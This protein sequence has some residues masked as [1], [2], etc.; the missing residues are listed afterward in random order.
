MERDDEYQEYK[1]SLDTTKGRGYIENMSDNTDNSQFKEKT[2]NAEKIN[3]EK[4]ENNA[5]IKFIP[6]EICQTERS[7]LYEAICEETRLNDDISLLEKEREK[8]NQVINSDENL[9]NAYLKNTELNNVIKKLSTMFE[10]DVYLNEIPN[11]QNYLINQK[12]IEDLSSKIDEN[13]K[14]IKDID[15]RLSEL[16]N[17][18][19]ELKRQIDKKR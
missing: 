3:K 13:K 17:K 6:S 2:D 9:Y 15:S 18:L 5:N 1:S 11:Y 8:C 12:E 16:Q 4:N 14:R 19:S 10:N 7:M